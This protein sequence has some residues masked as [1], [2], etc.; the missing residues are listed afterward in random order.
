MFLFLF[1]L[2][3]FKSFSHQ[4]ILMV[5]HWSLSD[6]KSP[7]VSRILLSISADLNRTVI[8]MV[9]TCIFISS[10]SRPFTNP[11]VTILSTP[12]TIGITVT[13]MFHSFF[14]SR[15]KSRY[16]SLFLPSFNFTLWSVGTAKSTIL[17]VLCFL[18]TIT[19]SC[20][21]TEIR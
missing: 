18:L 14:S 9:S 10:S 20:C 8:W 13:F 3:S 12:I 16:L 19:R 21:Q 1:L 6:S 11:L 7:Q 4:L 15:G 5:F 17:Q 2:Y